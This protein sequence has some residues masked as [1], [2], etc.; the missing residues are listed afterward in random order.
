MSE[1]VG[2]E[3]GSMDAYEHRFVRLSVPAHSVGAFSSMDVRGPQKVLGR[4]YRVGISC[5]KVCAT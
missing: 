5:A 4:S 3:F 1:S 2:I